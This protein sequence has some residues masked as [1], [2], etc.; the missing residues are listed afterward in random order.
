MCMLVFSLSFI[1]SAWSG[2]GSGTEGDPFL[3]TTC[4]QL[5]EVGSYVGEAYSWTHWAVSNNID[6]SDTI[7]WNNGDGFLS[8]GWDDD[9][10]F[11]GHFDGRGYTISDLYVHRSQSEVVGLFG[12]NKGTISNVLLENVDMTLYGTY[13]FGTFNYAGGLTCYNQGTIDSCNVTGTVTGEDGNDWIG[14]LTSSNWGTIINSHFS[15]TVS[16]D[17]YVGGLT[18]D[19]DVGTIINSYSTGTVIGNDYTGGLVAYTYP[20]TIENSYSTSNVIGKSYTGGLIGYLGWF[21]VGNVENCYATGD[22]TATGDSVGGLV[23]YLA[24]GEATGNLQNSYAT[25]DVSGGQSIGGLV[26]ET[27]AGTIISNCYAIGNSDATGY[28][29][30]GLIGYNAGTVENSYSIGSP[31]GVED[32]G[33]L[34]GFSE[35]TVTNCFWDTETSGQLTSSGGTGKTTSEMKDI[36]TFSNAGWTIATTTNNQN[37]GY[38]YLLSGSWVIYESQGIIQSILGVGKTTTSDTL[39]QQE[40][41]PTEEQSP[42]TK[43]SLFAGIKNFFQK[44]INWFSNIF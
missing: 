7:S 8:I 2:S 20:T 39:V 3:I 9:N 29:S 32:V 28:W 24:T 34:I 22:V 4:S 40:M 31:I 35:G 6:C 41:L 27:E 14:G 26:G 30:G 16:G 17:N 11:E 44:I 19:N 21:E 25:G 42:I 37:S 18:A 38:P 12:T 43:I 15:G 13:E 5:Q 1:S 36:T 10:S 33:G 23:G